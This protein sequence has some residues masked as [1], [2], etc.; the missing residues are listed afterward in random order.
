MKI[1][2]SKMDLAEGI[3]IAQKAVPAKSPLPI[4]EGILLEAGTEI[5]LTGND[6]EI[7]IECFV[8]G[9]IR[10]GGSIVLNSRMFG[11]IVRRLPDAEV[12]LE[13]KENNQV[14][15]EC[16]NSH[17]ELKG[18]PATGFPAIPAI[19]KEKPFIISQGMLKEMLRQIVFAISV[20]ENRPI[21]TGALIECRNGELNIVSIDGFRLALRKRRMED[22]ASDFS[23]VVPGKTLNE[24]IKVL[25]A[26]DEDAYIYTANNQILFDMGNCKV[27]S[28]VLEGEFLNY[29]SI[30]PQGFETR[31]RVRTKDFLASMERAALVTM[32]EKKYPVK[33]TINNDKIVITSQTELGA[34]REEVRVDMEGPKLEIGFNPRY[35]MDAM[36]VIEDEMVDI[37][38]TTSIGP[39]TIKPLEDDNFTY[40]ILPIRIKNDA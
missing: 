9:D 39:C 24:I 22:E 19:K 25:Q 20:D 40:L 2:C 36:K 8:S 14:V 33:F 31:T 38:F 28:R 26:G 15:I 4:L 1:I 34:V 29:R 10:E 6:L 16:E 11:D 32:D 37:S 21:L 7:G 27:V 5:K 35:F 18:L 12:M 13:V 3:S 23:V 30:I 17:F